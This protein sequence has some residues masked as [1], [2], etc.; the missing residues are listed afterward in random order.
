MSPATET[1]CAELAIRFRR[2]LRQSPS[3]PQ[4]CGVAVQGLSLRA[5]LRVGFDGFNLNS[6][7]TIRSHIR[8]T[9]HTRFGPYICSPG[10]S[11]V[12]IRLVSARR[13][14]ARNAGSVCFSGRGRHGL[15]HA[16][17]ALR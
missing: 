2:L 4:V 1:A 10:S 16:M 15:L 5:A 7:A 3:L 8:I 17:V 11:F 13:A 9:V 6:S 14:G 12:L